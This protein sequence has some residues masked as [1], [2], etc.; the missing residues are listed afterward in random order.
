MK[1]V[2]FVPEEILENLSEAEREQQKIK[3]IAAEQL[4]YNILKFKYL[5]SR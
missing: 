1:N 4:E 5:Q 3:A 2:F